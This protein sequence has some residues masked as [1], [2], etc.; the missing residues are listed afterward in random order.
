MPLLS[1]PS[2]EAQQV[3]NLFR[4]FRGGTVSAFSQ[5]EFSMCRL[6]SCF[7][8][9]QE[10]AE[11]LE[12]LPYNAEA[13]SETFR[14]VFEANTKLEPF[15]SEARE[16]C[17]AFDAIITLRSYMAHGFARIDMNQ[18]VVQMR[19]FR[20]EKGNEWNEDQWDIAFDKLEP[21]AMQIDALSQA[22]VGLCIRVSK[23]FDLG[24]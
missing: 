6:L 2:E 18:R 5:I 11:G 3:A 10:F 14:R 7:R 21:W 13:R 22:A 12:R 4:W 19:K 9:T 23:T 1:D 20:P 8:K 16:I 24:F 17:D 15:V